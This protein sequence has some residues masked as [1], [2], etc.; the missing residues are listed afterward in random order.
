MANKERQ[1]IARNSEKVRKARLY[2]LGSLCLIA[3][4]LLSACKISYTTVPSTPVVTEPS[5][6]L[7]VIPSATPA[8]TLP[9]I[10]SPTSIPFD[11]LGTI[12]MDFAALLCNADWM[13]GSQHLTPCPGVSADHSGGYATLYKLVPE[14][15]PA[16]TPI[17]LMVPNAGALFLRYPSY[18]VGLGDRFR[19]TL[20]CAASAPCDVEFA[21]QYY[22]TNGRYYELYKWDYRTGEPPIDVDADLSALAGQN[23]AFALVLRLFHATI[24]PQND[25]GLWVAPH[26]YRPGP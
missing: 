6:T 23:V 16:N 24:S 12:G 13:N 10:P 26:I 22:D 2:V 25:N 15:Y 21:L 18:K 5:P 4:S 1:S 17:R 9:P 20:R 11:A 19:T 3:S 14:E 8:P 7:T